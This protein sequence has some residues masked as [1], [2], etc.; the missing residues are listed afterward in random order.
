MIAT[1]TPLARHT[2]L[3]LKARRERLGVPVAYAKERSP[4]INQLMVAVAAF[5]LLILTGL[6]SKKM[7]AGDPYPVGAISYMKE[8]RLSGNI[9][10]DFQWGEYVIW[11]MPPASKVFIDGRYD[12]VYP[13][14]V[15]DDYMA[16]TNGGSR[17]QRT[18]GQLSARFRPRWAKERSPVQTGH[19]ATR[20]EGDLSRRFLC[21]VRP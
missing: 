21:P 5:E 11:H 9:L 2:T 19:R 16:F 20:V 12:T 18:S 6:F 3:A 15:I 4:T 7:A 10:A 14:K 8:H 13:P 1:V 17:R